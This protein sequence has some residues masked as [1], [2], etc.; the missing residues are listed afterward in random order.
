MDKKGSKQQER[1]GSEV[2]PQ[3]T[4]RTSVDLFSMPKMDM[5]QIETTYDKVYPTF[6]TLD[7]NNPVEFYIPPSSRQTSLKDS[8]LYMRFKITDKDNADITTDSKTLPKPNFFNNVFSNLTV[9]VNGKALP[10]VNNY[11]YASLIHRVVDNKEPDREGS[12]QSEMIV[13]ETFPGTLDTTN[14]FFKY[15]KTISTKGKFE[16]CAKL[17]Y[18]LFDQGRN[19]PDGPGLRLRFRRSPSN[20]ALYGVNTDSSPFTD[21]LHIEDAVLYVKRVTVHDKVDEMLKKSLDDGNPYLLP[22]DFFDAMSYTVGKGTQ[23]HTSE[24]LISGNLPSFVCVGLVDSK[25]F[26]GTADKHPQM[27]QDLGLASIN[28]LI[29]GVPQIINGLDFNVSKDN[30]MVGYQMLQQQPSASWISP[31]DYTKHG[32]FLIPYDLRKAQKEGRFTLSKTGTMKVQLSFHKELPE[33]IN[34]VVYYVNPS[35]VSID[36]FNQVSVTPM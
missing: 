34:V 36:K 33:N 17:N 29:D 6:S 20:F 25:A 14:M 35:L 12:L 31:A 15:F 32:Y 23:T 8:F 21:K 2:T 28:L 26:H 27:F 5:T 1:D 3:S 24:N 7:E 13:K 4:Y 11:G 9:E 19:W 30:Y 18:G 16:L 10:S 22:T